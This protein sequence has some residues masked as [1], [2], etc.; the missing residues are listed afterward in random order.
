MA[1]AMV[2]G[3]TLH[4]EEVGS[5]QPIV[6]TPGGRWGRE[7]HRPLAEL[8]A[9]HCRG[10][11][12]DRR[13]CGQSDVVIGGEGSEA[14]ICADDLAELIRQLGIAPAYVCEYA[15]ARVGLLLAMRHP[16]VV[17]ALLLGWPCGGSVAAQRLG[18]GQYGAFIEAAEQGGM[19]AVVEKPFI[20]S[21]GAE[22]NPTSRERLLAMDVQE[23]IRVMRG[24]QAYF[25][26]SAN[27]PIAGIPA[28]EEQVASI[29]T[30]TVIVAGD[31]DVHTLTSARTLHRLIPDSEYHDPPIPD[32]V[33]KKARGTPNAP[34]V[35]A[36]SAGP[37][38]LD[39][40]RR[41]EAK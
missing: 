24:W 40:L 21:E 25:T 19:A 1:T 15:G 6:F 20:R 8:M 32:D 17:K 27:L 13:S 35:Q 2:N 33:W 18:N 11:I 39:F 3:V 26:N 41:L 34:Q 31:D 9:S 23:F 28:T 36:E 37:I 14:E 7:Y 12:Y 4:Y 16:E 22:E 30:P 10:I 5:G 38:F 29:R